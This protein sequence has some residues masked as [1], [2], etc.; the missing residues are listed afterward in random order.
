MAH[1]F[2]SYARKD[3]RELALRLK[4]DLERA[5]HDAWLDTA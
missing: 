2:I 5:G 4:A 3:G 1:I